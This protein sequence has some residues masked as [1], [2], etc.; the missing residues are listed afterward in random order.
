MMIVGLT[1]PD[2]APTDATAAVLDLVERSD[3]PPTGRV[4]VDLALPRFHIDRRGARNL[5]LVPL[6]HAMGLGVLLT[7]A[8]DLGAMSPEPLEVG[9]ALQQAMIEVDEEGT[10]AV[11]TVEIALRAAGMPAPP[12]E[13][14]A[15]RFDRPFAYAVRAGRAG[16]LLFAGWVA[17]PSSR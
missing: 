6:L 9:E 12:A 15:I 17:D 11:A 16:P 14:V 3:P 10:T 1:A 4:Q 2:L 7:D 8:A 5:D 13:Q